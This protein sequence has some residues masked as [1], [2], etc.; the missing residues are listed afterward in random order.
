LI[1]AG[2]LRYLVYDDH[3]HPAQP[4]LHQEGGA[5]LFPESFSKGQI[6][7]AVAA[8]LKKNPKCA[9]SYW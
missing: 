2:L 3:I 4:Y 8:Y 5:L 6:A 9:V 1:L 7:E